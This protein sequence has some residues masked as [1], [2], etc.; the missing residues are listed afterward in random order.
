[1]SITEAAVLAAVM[2]LSGFILGAAFGLE[3]RR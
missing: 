3:A 1:M 2:W